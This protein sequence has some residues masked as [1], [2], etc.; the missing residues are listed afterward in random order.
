MPISAVHYRN[1][2]GRFDARNRVAALPARWQVTSTALR[3]ET[4]LQ[5]MMVLL[6]VSNVAAMPRTKARAP[7]SREAAATPARDCIPVPRVSLPGALHA[8]AGMLRSPL[9]EGVTDAENAWERYQGVPC[10]PSFSD[11]VRRLLQAGDFAIG[12][13]EAVVLGPRTTSVVR[14]VAD[15][16][17]AVAD[18]LEGR[19]LD[20][21]MVMDILQ[22]EAGL[23]V[24][25]AVAAPAR[26]PEAAGVGP[27]AGGVAA[28][29]A[30]PPP[31]QPEPPVAI[32]QVTAELRGGRVQVQ[33]DGADVDLLV[34]DGQLQVRTGAGDV[35]VQWDAS[36]WQWKRSPVT[37]QGPVNMRAG[38]SIRVFD[39]TAEQVRTQA[40]LDNVRLRLDLL[41]P[42]GILYYQDPAT[43]QVGN[44]V[45]V[46]GRYYAAT[47]EPPHGLRI[48]TLALRQRDGIYQLREQPS[49][50]RGAAPRCRRAPGSAC[51][52]GQPQ[53]SVGLSRILRQHHAQAL[54]AEQ[55]G[56]RGIMADPARPGWYLSHNGARLRH[57]LQF[58]GR[59][60]RVRMRQLDTF[61][62]RL[63]VYLPRAAGAGRLSRRGHV[64]HR[65]ADIRQSLPAQE[66]RFMTQAEFNVEYRGMPTLEAAHVY[67]SAI[68][69]IG[70]LR[71]SQLQRAAI[72]SYLLRRRSVDEF[73]QSGGVLPPVFNDAAQV[74]AR[75]NRGL[76]RIPPHA[77][78]VYTALAV[79]PPQLATLE[80]GQ[81]LYS[82][83]F[84][85]ASGDRGRAVAAAARSGDGPQ[86]TPIVV[87]LDM[88]RHAHP[89][90]LISLQDEAQVL[91]GNRVLFK[92]IAR[93][94]GELHLEEV[95][96]ARQA[97]GALGAQPLRA[98]ALR[99]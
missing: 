89:T 99:A 38:S 52:A 34:T 80:A 31:A 27:A 22:G 77:G 43:G 58:N 55:A 61:T 44:A 93:A 81:T 8:A 47:L 25:P 91:I 21:G 39:H 74:A 59:Y 94:P 62:Q 2:A 56:Q 50:V 3:A 11:G 14:V 54:S 9:T 18:G 51:A 23:R 16:V 7:S 87:T 82:D 79:D 90:G 37:A 69:H 60:F 64:A 83:S 57:Y 15:A 28:V 63:S 85:V 46:D 92:I 98:V 96:A 1:A 4:P 88:Q 33:L 26:E 13:F 78:R 68:Q 10:A 66:H 86:G 97:M 5:L 45:C 70:R 72:R 73:L 40:P 75:I 24:D 42:D 32:A 6:L 95:G 49:A 29:A 20:P 17:D 12:L 35:P 84:M 19:P 71:L 65:I 36:A 76:A 67:E 48:G 30:E 53:F 41:G